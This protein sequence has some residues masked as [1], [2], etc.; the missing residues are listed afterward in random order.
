MEV[1]LVDVEVTGNPQDGGGCLGDD[2]GRE[3]LGS[4]THVGP[5]AVQWSRLGCLQSRKYSFIQQTHSKHLLCVR[6]YAISDKHHP[7]PNS[8]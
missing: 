2:E 7:F 3:G 5:R 6:C 1:G 8:L 4:I